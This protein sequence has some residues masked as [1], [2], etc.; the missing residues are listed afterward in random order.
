[1][2]SCAA[3]RRV[4]TKA[5][6]GL[7]MI[8]PR[9]LEL[10]LGQEDLQVLMSVLPLPMSILNMCVTKWGHSHVQEAHPVLAPATQQHLP[11]EKLY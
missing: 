7:R 10:G 2:E 9:R 1:M 8:A 3:I 5:E 6:E 11:W 4:G